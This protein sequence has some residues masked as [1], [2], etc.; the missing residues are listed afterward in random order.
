MAGANIELPNCV[1]ESTLYIFTPAPT[2]RSISSAMA[3]PCAFSEKCE[4]PLRATRAG[5]ESALQSV[6]LAEV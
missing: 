1:V 3:A 5:A 4:L 6:R 2:G